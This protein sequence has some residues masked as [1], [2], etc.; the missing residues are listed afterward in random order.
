M[1]WKVMKRKLLGQ[2]EAD[3]DN[4]EAKVEYISAHRNINI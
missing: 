4:P 2:G 3:L 1:R